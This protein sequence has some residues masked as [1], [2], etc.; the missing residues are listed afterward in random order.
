VN[1][2]AAATTCGTLLLTTAVS[3][4]LSSAARAQQPQVLTIQETV[5]T[6]RAREEALFDVPISLSL[7]SGDTIDESGIRNL[8]DLS[9]AVPN[10][11]VTQDPIGDKIN[12]RGIFTSEVASLEQSVSTFVDGVNRGRGTQSRFQFLDLERVEVLRGP[13]GTLFG[14]NT[15]GGALNLITRKPTTQL[16]ASFS[17]GY[18]PELE[19]SNLGGFLSGPFS[20]SVRG[21]LAYAGSNQDKGYIDNNFYG[22]SSPQTQNNSVR[23]ILDWDLSPMTLVRLRAEYQDFESD[24]EAFGLRT[25]GPLQSQLDAFGVAGGSLTRTAI[26]QVRGGPLDIGSSGIMEGDAQEAALT[27][28]QEFASDA[29]LEIIAAFSSLDFKRRIDADFSPLDLVGF[30][31]SEDSQQTSLSLRLL[32]ADR[33][34]VRYVA[35]V[36]YQRS[37]LELTAL[38]SLNPV[39]AQSVLAPI[40]QSVGLSA[41]D[42]QILSATAGLTPGFTPDGI[43]SQLA[44][45]GSAAMVENC[46]TYGATLNLPSPVARLNTLDQD[47][48]VMAV[49]G[50]ADF[51]LTNRLQLTV[52]LRYTVE[53]KRAR[54]TV[55]GRDFGG[56]PP[57]P[58]LN[59]SLLVFLEAIPHD[60]GRD[61]LDRSENKLTYST[62]LRWALTDRVN[63]Y[64]SA[65]SGFK[66]GGFNSVAFGADPRQAEFDA[67]EVMSYEI[68]LK[69]NLL[70]GR[71]QFN[72][73]YFFTEID[74]LQVAQFTGDASFIVQNAAEAEVHGLELDTR[75]QL[76]KNL[77][78]TAAASYTDFQFTSFRN[79]GCTTQQLQALRQ[80]AYIQG[81]MQVANGDPAGL[82]TQLF[83]SLQTLQ[84][85]S[86][87][88]INDLR[89]RT[90]EQV[91]RYTA[92]FGVDYH[93]EF[94]SGSFA[95]DTLAEIVWNDRQFRQTDLDPVTES[96]SFAKTNLSLSFYRPG[97]R[98][99]L[100]LVGRNIFDK[101]T[102][103]Y[104][105]DTPLF[106]NARQQIVDRPRTVKLQLQYDFE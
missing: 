90:A 102:F 46:A 49:Y 67:E 81:A 64:V 63:T 16:A 37:E 99:T 47:G 88:G 14:K 4:A 5:V 15:V 83:G 87:L 71:A 70:E 85:C 18:D 23:A 55:V 51:Q 74:D 7:V 48:E 1:R 66:A 103:S 72:A 96:G 41:L 24:G 59:Q 40:C 44:R 36:Y 52:G 86:A 57:N 43:A 26:G 10:F 35:G 29:S 33:G 75:L 22:D 30:D 100:M 79:A 32:S 27:F 11:T 61:Q 93:L 58:T 45:A 77:A 8:E 39:A 106:E 78:L 104:A 98:W 62:S 68:G 31:D 73:A 101:R 89:G 13:Q 38:T 97:N 80:S 12:I 94:G 56:G 76:T 54:Q 69:T 50:Q 25:A 20:D 9:A 19:E 91:P 6:S 2:D 34:R 17:A 3:L 65:S 60:F 53:D 42:S 92:Q 95:I 105:N 82:A 21:R 84:N 28:K